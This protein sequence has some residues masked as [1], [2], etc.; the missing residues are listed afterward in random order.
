MLF[1]F[2]CKSHSCL[3][4]VAT[5]PLSSVFWSMGRSPPYLGGD[6]KVRG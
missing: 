2:V 5:L 3:I 4:P 6:I 1:C